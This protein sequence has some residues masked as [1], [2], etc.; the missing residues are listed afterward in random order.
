MDGPDAAGRRGARSSRADLRHVSFGLD[1]GAGRCA[2]ADRAWRSDRARRFSNAFERTTTACGSWLRRY[3]ALEVLPAEAGWSA[4]F[5]VP[6]DASE[7][8]LVLELIERDG[9]L[10]HPG[11]FF[12][13]PHEAFL[14]VSL[15]P[16]RRTFREGVA[17]IAGAASWLT[18]RR[19]F[20]RAGIVQRAACSCRSS[21]SRRAAAG[22]S[23]R[24][25]ISCRSARWLARAGL[26]FVQLLPVNEM[27]DGQ[28]SPYSALSAMAIDPIFICVSPT[29]RTSS[30]PAAR[31]HVRRRGSRAL[32]EARARAAS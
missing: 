15:L 14:V 23:A 30:R 21:R 22:A 28:N 7:E 3:P 13:F 31:T 2:R 20:R 24:F 26:D 27:E 32:V 1:A 25:P 12:D 6:L 4:V 8:D 10:V 9:V 11:F 18:S 5:R 29:C 19:P 16:P 17:R